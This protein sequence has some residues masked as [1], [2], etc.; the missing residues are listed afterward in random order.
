[1][2][3]KAICWLEPQRPRGGWRANHGEVAVAPWLHRIY[4]AT[5]R[6]FRGPIDWI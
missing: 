1:M 5:F 2:K 3:S 6:G 4:F